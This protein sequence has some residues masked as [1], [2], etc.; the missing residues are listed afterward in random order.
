MTTH[1]GVVK[2]SDP[3]GFSFLSQNVSGNGMKTIMM[4]LLGGILLYFSAC[5]AW[6]NPFPIP[7]LHEAVVHG[8]IERVKTLVTQGADVNEKER[9]HR[10]TPLHWAVLHRQRDIMEFLLTKGSHVNAGDINSNTPLHFAAVIG[11]ATGAELLLEHGADIHRKN[12]YDETSLY[13]ATWNMSLS[14]VMALP[15]LE[16]YGPDET[17]CIDVHGKQHVVELLLKHG[18]NPDEGIYNA[19][20]NGDVKIVTLLIAQ[21]ANVNTKKGLG[22]TPLHA[23]AFRGHTPVVQL[24]LDHGAEVNAQREDGL[25]PL[26]AAMRGSSDNKDEVIELLRQHGGIAI[27]RECR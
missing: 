1:K 11:Y 9:W 5:S 27:E 13:Y 2:H 25:T 6:N 7:A 8:D 18:A 17:K 24:L 16:R 10:S 20:K 4:V 21:G 15:L 19:A 12:R 14:Q 23:A 26:G 3:N 22:G